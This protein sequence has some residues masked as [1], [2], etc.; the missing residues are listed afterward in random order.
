[1][2]RLLLPLLGSKTVI[3]A[4]RRMLFTCVLMCHTIYPKENPQNLLSYYSVSGEKLP[5]SW[6]DNPNVHRLLMPVQLPT[7]ALPNR[8]S[9]IF[10][11]AELSQRAPIPIANPLLDTVCIVGGQWGAHYYS[12]S[13]DNNKETY[14]FRI[15]LL[16]LC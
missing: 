13:L 12:T 10:I 6:L 8:L 14:C 1:M 11:W 5:D 7:P 3:Q 2:K 4:D 15:R 16:S 9:L